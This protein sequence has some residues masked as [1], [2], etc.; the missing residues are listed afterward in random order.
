[1]NDLIRET[2]EIREIQH[3]VLE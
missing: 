1:M 2:Q 3:A